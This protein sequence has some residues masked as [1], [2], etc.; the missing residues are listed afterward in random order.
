V[1]LAVLGSFCILHIAYIVVAYTT[2]VY[3]A[4]AVAVAVAYCHVAMS[5]LDIWG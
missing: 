2:V 1:L 4:V 5:I 3:T